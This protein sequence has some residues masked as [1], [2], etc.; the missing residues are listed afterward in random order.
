MKHLT[1]KVLLVALCF[2]ILLTGCASD[3]GTWQEQ[4]DLGVR[5]LAEG[6]YQ[7]AILAF[8]A[9]I[10]VDPKNAQAYIGRAKAI[11]LSGETE[12]N[13]AAARADYQEAADLG[14]TSE[15]VW[16]GLADVYIREGDYDKALEILKEGL[17]KTGGNN[18]IAQKSRNLKAERLP[19]TREKFEGSPSMMPPGN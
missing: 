16:L 7:E 14:D 5:Y 6:N 13:L 8:N 2:T 1:R 10:E 15:E 19:T 12:E 4:Y 18:A 3:E 17:E 11:V 9:A